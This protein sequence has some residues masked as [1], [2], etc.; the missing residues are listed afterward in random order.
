MTLLDKLASLIAGVGI[1]VFF[2][3]VGCV[4]ESL[5]KPLVDYMSYLR[6]RYSV[7][8]KWRKRKSRLFQD[9]PYEGMGMNAKT[10]HL[11]FSRFKD[12]P[13]GLTLMTQC[14]CAKYYTPEQKFFWTD[15]EAIVAMEADLRRLDKLEPPPKL[16]VTREYYNKTLEAQSK[17]HPRRLPWGKNPMYGL[18]MWLPFHPGRL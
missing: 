15:L 2:Y 8:V 3:C 1:G 17:L 5:A 11:F 10:G 4:I 14:R 18:P 12:N 16:P 7:S 13:P 9:A 6:H